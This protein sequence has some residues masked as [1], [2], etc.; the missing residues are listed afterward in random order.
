MKISKV[1]AATL[2]TLVLTASTAHAGGWRGYHGHYSNHHHNS[3]GWAIALG[4]TS[5]LLGAAL[6][7]E[8]VTR[9]QYVAAPAYTYASPQYPYP[10]YA[11]APAPPPPAAY[12][13]VDDAY[14]RG[15]QAGLAEARGYEAGRRQAA[16]DGP[17]YDLLDAR[18]RNS[19]DSP[20]Y[21]R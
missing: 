7:A 15:Y 14:A 2:A 9:P 16:D 5:G 8:A 20:Y 21:G 4:V 12:N 13:T 10:S 11:P 18:A 17:Q 3:D 6:L 1:V 19:D